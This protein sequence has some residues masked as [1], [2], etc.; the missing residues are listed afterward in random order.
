M[1]L[2]LI[3]ASAMAL[4]AY[5]WNESSKQNKLLASESASYKAQ[6][7]RL[8]ADFETSRRELDRLL[9]RNSYLE[10]RLQAFSIENDNLGSTNEEL[11]KLYSQAKEEANKIKFQLIELEERMHCKK[12]KD[13][14]KKEAKQKKTTIKHLAK[15]VKE[16]KK[17]IKDD[18]KLTAKLKK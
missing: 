11:A 7:K 3:L 5:L 14:E 18:K 17:S 4:L 13:N 6:S 2:N 16:A 12:M 8:L 15:D 10:G 1:I 9:D